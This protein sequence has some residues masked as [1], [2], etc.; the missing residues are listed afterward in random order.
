MSTSRARGLEGLWEEAGSFS[1]LATTEILFS[2]F[3]PAGVGPC[4]VIAA[5]MA[6]PVDG[7]EAH[8]T[9]REFTRG[10]WK[11]LS[12]KAKSELSATIEVWTCWGLPDGAGG[13]L[14]F[15][16]DFDRTCTEV[17]AIGRTYAGCAQRDDWC[18]PPTWVYSLTPDT[19]HEMRV[20]DEP[21]RN[22]GGARTCRI[23]QVLFAG[24][25]GSASLTAANVFTLE[26][27][28]PLMPIRLSAWE[29][30]TFSATAGDALGYARI[31][32]SA[33]AMLAVSFNIYSEHYFDA[34]EGTPPEPE[35]TQEEEMRYKERIADLERELESRNRQYADLEAD[36]VT[37][38]R[39]VSSERD[40]LRQALADTQN[41][42]S[43]QIAS[44]QTELAAVRNELQQTIEAVPQLIQQN[45]EAY[46]QQRLNQLLADPNALRDMLMQHAQ[47]SQDPRTLFATLQ[48]MNQ[49]G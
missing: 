3:F 48:A 12:T 14:D 40:S 16:F 45:L 18:S 25:R 5:V 32:H 30:G 17:Y 9:P 26:N 10:H 35:H 42:A 29:S 13:F 19:Q 41:A 11:R 20:P 43:S 49:L 47:S 34:K 15:N 46:F 8:C 37:T 27:F 2:Q 21:S 4:N 36:F 6:R 7:A 22:E 24:E 44:L 33:S 1:G 39:E 31:R 38:N 23:G 28:D